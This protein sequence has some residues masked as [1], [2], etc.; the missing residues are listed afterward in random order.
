MSP[1]GILIAEYDSAVAHELT[2]HLEEFGYQVVGIVSSGKEALR[3]IETL[4]PDLVLMNFHLKGRS[5]AYR[6]AA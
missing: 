2:A 5:M 4:H 1:T 3:K 6:Q